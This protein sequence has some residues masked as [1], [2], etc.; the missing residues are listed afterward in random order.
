MNILFIS[1]LSGLVSAGPSWSI[2]ARIKAQEQFDNILW[3]NLY[4]ATMPHWEAVKSFH[5]ISEYKSLSLCDLPYPFNRPDIVVFENFYSMRE[6]WFSK[7]LNRNNIPYVV[8]PRGSLT[9]A[10]RNN[11]KW[12]KKRIAH[13]LFFDR[14]L[15]KSAAIQY[16]T[17]REAEMSTPNDLNSFIM[18]NGICLPERRK[19]K[20]S[21]NSILCVFIGRLDIYT[22]G[23]DILIS[24]L[25]SIRSE[26]KANH[27][28]LNLYGPINKDYSELQ[29]S[30]QENNLDDVVFLKG[31]ISGKQKEEVLMESDVFILTSRTEGHPMGLI[32]ALSY[33][34]PSL[35]SKGTN[36]AK[37]IEQ[38]NSGWIC[39]G[40]TSESIA[41]AFKQMISEVDSL[42][43]KSNN[44]RCLAQQYDWATIA[45]GFHDEMLRLL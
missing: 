4:E 18:P 23:L 29:K 10:S 26:I 44:A 14:F 43:I 16:L 6:V 12:L 3:I 7:E 35:V 2:P 41:H 24:A 39:E 19:S 34:M 8:V 38:T 36:M 28:I 15:R 31:E 27:L 11:S 45:Q 21:A 30:I 40:L 17:S 33:G 5:K 9:I 25:A 42:Q 13:W 32:E 20:F 1:A 37:E 22:K